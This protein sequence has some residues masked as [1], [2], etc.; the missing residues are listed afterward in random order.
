MSRRLRHI[1]S[2]LSGCIAFFVTAPAILAQAQLWL[3]DWYPAIDVQV[4][5]DD[6]VNR[7]FDGDG[8]K[9]DLII[10]PSLRIEHQTP[11]AD[12]LVG[13]LAGTVHGALYGRYN[14]LNFIAPGVDAGLRQQLGQ[15]PDSPVASASM[16]LHYE[17]HNQDARFGAEVRPRL[18]LTSEFGGVLLATAFYEFDARF[19][20]DNPVYDRDGH[21]LG[22]SGD[23][24][25]TDQAAVIVGYVYRRGDVLVHQPRQDLGLEIRGERFPIDTFRDR[26]DAVNIPSGDTHTMTLG[27]RYDLSLY[28]T[29][30]VGL[31]YE[32]IRAGGDSYPSK[33]FVFGVSHLL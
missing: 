13:Y 20:S 24:Y 27:L 3:G 31:Q 8:E 23:I 6:N 32:E 28:T 1:L 29:L 17:F 21:N 4:T 30:R 33:Q 10:E 22:F 15:S 7:S 12:G 5:A 18:A 11:L 14:K 2:V 26:Y 25:L 16:R 9:S 19:A